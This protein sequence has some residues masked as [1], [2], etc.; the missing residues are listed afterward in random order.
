MKAIF[1]RVG[2]YIGVKNNL[3]INDKQD[4]EFFKET[5]KHNVVI[6]GRKTCDSL[7][8]KLPDRVSV[9]IT[10]NE[11]YESDKA[12]VV[13][14]NLESLVLPDESLCDTFVIGGSETLDLFSD[15]ITEMFVTEF[16]GSVDESIEGLVMLPESIQGFINSWHRHVVKFIDKGVIVRYVKC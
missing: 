2:K 4:L 6:M 12:D 16:I 9:V 10:S 3:L 14:N 8:K 11:N 5:T 7:P 1:S 15:N 13:I